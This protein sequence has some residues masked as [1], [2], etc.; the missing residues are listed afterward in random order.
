MSVAPPAAMAIFQSKSVRPCP[1]TTSIKYLVDAGNTR[2]IAW[3]MIMRTAPRASRRRCVHTSSRASAHADDQCIFLF[4]SGISSPLRAFGSKGF[5]Q[6][7]K[8]RLLQ[9]ARTGLALAGLTGAVY[10]PQTI[11]RQR[12]LQNVQT[13]PVVELNNHPAVA[14]LRLRLSNTPA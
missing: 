2:P 11:S 6:V 7:V 4:T 8:M 9:I 3:L 10:G 1:I 12:S 5:A 14:E 13:P